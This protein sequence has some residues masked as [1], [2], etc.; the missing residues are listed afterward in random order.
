MARGETV[1][2]T[3]NEPLGEQNPTSFGAADESTRRDVQ[4]LTPGLLR[5]SL[6]RIRE[7]ATAHLAPWKEQ[8]VRV[9]KGMDFDLRNSAGGVLGGLKKSSDRLSKPAE[10][11]D[12]AALQASL[13]HL[14]APLETLRLHRSSPASPEEEAFAAAHGLRLDRMGD[15][16]A[17]A[18]LKMHQLSDLAV[19]GAVSLDPKAVSR[20]LERKRDVG[21]ATL[22]RIEDKIAITRSRKDKKRLQEMRDEMR[23]W[24]ANRDARLESVQPIVDE[25]GLRTDAL[26]RGCIMQSRRLARA[27]EMSG[28]AAGAGSAGNEAARRTQMAR[29]AI[30]FSASL[31]A[32]LHAARADATAALE[33]S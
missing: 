7:A 2:T 33:Q 12:D 1:S 18:A 15:H 6:A 3:M 21:D 5:R 32:F 14:S 31:R 17:T 26:R 24:L 28:R 9:P 20:I 27:A 22:R 19:R 4:A 13:S 8:S 16:L 29:E 23:N 11:G 30:E 25:L 10:G